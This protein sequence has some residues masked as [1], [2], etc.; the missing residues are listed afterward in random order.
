[1]CLYW[2]LF[3][4]AP[5]WPSS[6][7]DRSSQSLRGPDGAH[8]F[9]ANQCLWVRQRCQLMCPT[10][11]PPFVSLLTGTI[12]LTLTSDIPPPRS[13]SNLFPRSQTNPKQSLK[14]TDP[15]QLRWRRGA[16]SM[17]KFLRTYG[18]GSIDPD[19]AAVK[20]RGRRGRAHSLCA[21]ER[22]Y[23]AKVRECAGSRE[24]ILKTGN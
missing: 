1:M 16:R 17:S 24:K 3:G 22:V 23:A 11:L 21:P 2:R 18:P 8:R 7:D 6:S 14:L 10:R 9:F 5:L 13:R 4:V 19:V 20:E 12:R 15:Q